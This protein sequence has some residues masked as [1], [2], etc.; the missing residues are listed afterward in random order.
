M[1][2]NRV[3]LAC[4]ISHCLTCIKT[5][6]RKWNIKH[7]NTRKARR[8]A[9]IW[10]ICCWMHFLAWINYSCVIIHMLLELDGSLHTCTIYHMRQFCSFFYC[11]AWFDTV[12]FM[13]AVSKQR[14]VRWCGRRGSIPLSIDYVWSVHIDRAI[15]TPWYTCCIWNSYIKNHH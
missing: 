12:E 15:S 10:K 13:P 3:S 1:Y 8:S 11:L 9:G 2:G 6:R 7:Y 4:F 5:L 14:A